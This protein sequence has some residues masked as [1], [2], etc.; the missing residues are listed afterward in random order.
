LAKIKWDRNSGQRIVTRKEL[1]PHI[2]YEEDGPKLY[3]L[4]AKGIREGKITKVSQLPSALSTFLYNDEEV[5]KATGTNA[6]F[7][8]TREYQARFYAIQIAM[9]CNPYNPY[10]YK[11]C[12]YYVTV[13]SRVTG[14]QDDFCRE[15][16]KV[17]DNKDEAWQ[18]VYKV[19]E[20][21]RKRSKSLIDHLNQ[22]SEK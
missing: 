8:I 10:E 1:G 3:K 11:D 22:W 2:N 20:E 12:K 9:L 15:N 4:I 17:F 19:K 13:L 18:H 16:T 5:K 6:L 14:K 21:A 7:D